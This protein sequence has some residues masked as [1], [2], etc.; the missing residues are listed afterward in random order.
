MGIVLILVA[1]AC[2]PANATEASSQTTAPATSTT[3]VAPTTTT[4][5]TT[6]T[7][8]TSTSTTTTT[9]APDPYESLVA[10]ARP[11][12]TQLVAYDEPDGEPVPMEFIVPNPHQFGDPLTLMVTEGERGDDWLKIQIPMRP[13]GREGWIPVEDYTITST[14]TWAR[15]DLPTTS[16]KVYE[17]SELIAETQAAIGTGST[18]TPLGT[19]YVTSKRLNPPEEW[20]L[21]TYAIV[22]S[23]FSE[24]LETF[25]GGLPVI[26]IH[27]THDPDRELGRAVSHGCVRVPDDVIQFIAEHVPLGAPIHITG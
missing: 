14:R 25:S 16:V 8:T 1:A 20:F 17:G 7:A 23:G 27:G 13:N 9:E 6:T 2:A 21:G 5:T 19:F 26:A 18:P 15:V 12:I 24:A 10:T 22:L 11:H 4:S 3:T